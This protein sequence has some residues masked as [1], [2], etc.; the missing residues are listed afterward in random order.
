MSAARHRVRQFG[1]ALVARVGPRERAL[2][3]QIL[4]PGPAEL[5]GRMPRQDQ[6]HALDVL[7]A[8]QSQGQDAPELLA[9]ALL[10]DAAKSRD[11]R[12]WHR[13]AAVLLQSW[14]PE[15]LE[16]LA[17]AEPTS[18]RYAFWVQVHHADLSARLAQAAGCSVGTVELIRHHHDGEAMLRPPLE[19]W[20]RALRMADGEAGEKGA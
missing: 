13:V 8:L 1:R 18:W 2:G 20:L 11:V 7:R 15:W 5:F 4:P 16:R 9:A 14:R 10:H 3:A 12:I 19:G 6:R 17:S